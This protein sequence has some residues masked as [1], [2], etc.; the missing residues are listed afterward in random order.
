M[1]KIKFAI[2][3]SLPIYFKHLD[4]IVDY[5]VYCASML[6]FLKNKFH[7]LLCLMEHFIHPLNTRTTIG[8]GV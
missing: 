1:L 7:Y 2:S 6:N 8:I 3:L 5:C 4:Y